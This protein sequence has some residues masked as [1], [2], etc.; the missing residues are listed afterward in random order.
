VSLKN[1]LGDAGFV[2]RGF[3]F[4]AYEFIGNWLEERRGR[5]AC[6]RS[7]RTTM[8]QRLGC[9]AKLNRAAPVLKGV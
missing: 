4:Q 2:P 5:L 8:V 9:W 7:T 3:N 6:C 1:G